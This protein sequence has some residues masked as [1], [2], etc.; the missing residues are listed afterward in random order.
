G[1]IKETIAPEAADR[2]QAEIRLLAAVPVTA[3]RAAAQD[4][5]TAAIGQALVGQAARATV[6]LRVAGHAMAAREPAPVMAEVPVNLVVVSLDDTGVPAEAA[7]VTAALPDADRPTTAHVTVV[8]GTAVP[9]VT[10]SG[11]QTVPV[12]AV[13]ATAVPAGT[14]SGVPKAHVPA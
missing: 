10:V 11:A 12:P 13:R 14:A 8:P 6:G 4:R 2:P 1:R 7:P 5:A 9:A 3:A